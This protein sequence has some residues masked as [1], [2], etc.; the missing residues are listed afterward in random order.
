MGKI[1]TTK[2]MI[3]K[4]TKI[5]L[6]VAVLA[7]T[8]M[9]ALPVAAAGG[10]ISLTANKSTVSSGGMLIVAVYTNGGATP[11]N[12]VQVDLIYPASK[13]QYVGFSAS[14]SAFEIGASSVGG[15]GSATLARGTTTSISGS[16]LVGT[17]TFKALVSSGS[18]TIGVAGSSS[19]VSDGN[20]VAYGSSG[21]NV[22]FGV[23]AA[24]ASN[25]TATPAVP[26]D[27]TAPVISAVKIT[28]LT[29]YSATVVWKT[30]EPSDSVVEYGL[31]DKYG[32]ST[33]V[34]ASGTT[35][36]VTLNSSFLTPTTL[37][38]YRVKSA[39][40]AGNV[41]TG[42]DQT[43]QLPGVLVT[44]IV[45]GPDGKPLSGATVILDNDSET[46]DS[47]GSVTLRSSLGNKKL[48]TTYQG[49]TVQKPITVIKSAKPLP[50]FQLDLSKKPLN[51]WMLT[52]IGLF[53]ITIVLVGI[54]AL[55]FGSRILARITGTRIAKKINAPPDPVLEIPPTI[56]SEPAPAPETSKLEP[57]PKP[58]LSV[59]SL[60][61]PPAWPAMPKESEE[62]TIVVDNGKPLDPSS[63][64][65]DLMGQEPYQQ[66]AT[67]L[68]MSLKPLSESSSTLGSKPSA[69]IPV[70]K[71]S[72][73]RQAGSPSKKKSVSSI[74][75]S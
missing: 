24:A 1:I 73:S 72:S 55:L 20:P 31:D 58:K 39:D 40:S 26:K 30:N 9:P 18:A 75:E 32:L 67:P 12:A 53:V 54:D 3:Q 49:V 13:L 35:H 47:K 15:G 34:A 6:F 38:H 7:T 56:K 62:A 22:N 2:F 45:R 41:A 4:F 17:V 37:L 25:T 23:T 28:D 36:S 71:H 14:G 60:P 46:T 21:V 29:P 65:V 33:S 50:P 8:L 44:V 68:V 11:I 19:L 69:P 74:S 5:I 64:I 51:L 27:T 48:S 66:K 43:L 42:A 57:A 63:K 59:E 16:G 61:T 52:S 70:S 10:S